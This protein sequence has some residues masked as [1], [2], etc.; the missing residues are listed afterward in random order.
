M[1]FQLKKRLKI[2]F[3]SVKEPGVLYTRLRDTIGTDHLLNQDCHYSPKNFNISSFPQ[4]T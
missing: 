3:N 2:F 4:G 1:D